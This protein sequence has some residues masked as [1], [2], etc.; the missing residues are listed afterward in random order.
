MENC[1]T[2]KCKSMKLLILG[3]V[4]ILLDIYTRWDLW[5]VIGILLIIKAIWVT[6]MPRCP[7]CSPRQ[8]NSRPK[9]RR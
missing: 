4:I 8:S 7:Y 6:L 2:P 5:L 3:I 1:C 9:K